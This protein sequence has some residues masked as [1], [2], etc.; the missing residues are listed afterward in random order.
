ML[1]RLI[2]PYF[3]H[4]LKESDR[5]CDNVEEIQRCQLSWLLERGAKT[6]IGRELQLGRLRSYEEFR[7]SV[8]VTGYERM[9]PHVMKMIKGERNVLWLGRTRYFAQSSG[10]SDGRSKYIPITEESLQLSHFG[11]GEHAVSR[12]LTLYPESRLFDGKSLIL[13]GSYA[14]SL[15]LPPGRG[16]HVG[17]LSATLIDRLNPIAA[18][19]RTPSK[20][21][22][23]MADWR[24]KLPKLA[25]EVSRQRGVTNLSGV[26]SWMHT[27]LREVLRLTGA[28]ELHEV[29]PNLEVFFH[30]GIAMQ[31]Y[32]KLYDEIIDPERMHYLETY[33]ASEGFFA[34]QDR[35]DN[36]DMRLLLDVGTFYEFEPLDGGEPLGAWEVEAGKTYS[37]IITSCN[38]LWRY[39]LGDT[40]EVRSTSPLRIVIAG[41]TKH[42]INAFGEEVMV[43]NT[44]AALTKACAI[45]GALVLNYTAAPVYATA[46][47][48]GRHQWLI[49]FE[50][51][52]EDME[53][54]AE[55][56]DKKLQEEN[57]DYQ[58][59]R[60]G[61]LFLDRP[62]VIGVE[63]G[64]FDRW[65]ASTGKLGGQRKVPRLSNDRKIVES[66]LALK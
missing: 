61:G 47:S 5:R 54:F 8:N 32:K 58:A 23:L 34:V 66:M 1:T 30:G 51:A 22:A 10:T 39:P 36:S 26:P 57:S 60:T 44:D 18:L 19:T 7:E 37:L 45:S 49:E 35:R 52:P 25:A 53:A 14:N 56:L 28:R 50:R 62:E 40:V 9:R 65:L 43:H 12:Y 41:R 13:G 2:S 63:R 31:P 24:E 4:R 48:R 46:G 17:D 59:K 21:T 11:G 38:G 42:F 16:V 3:K 29:W 20:K 64:F 27:V 15:T 6:E 55:L 33:N